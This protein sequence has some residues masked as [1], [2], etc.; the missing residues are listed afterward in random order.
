MSLIRAGILDWDLFLSAN[1][2]RFRGRAAAPQKALVDF[3]LRFTHM[4]VAADDPVLNFFLKPKPPPQLFGP[5]ADIV[6][7]A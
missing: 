5:L 1:L 3:R 2:L 6:G 4:Y 7:Q